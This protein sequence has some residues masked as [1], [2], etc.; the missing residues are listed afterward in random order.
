MKA[1]VAVVAAT[2]WFG[3]AC[4]DGQPNAESDPARSAPPPTTQAEP[5]QTPSVPVVDVQP[6]PG[7]PPEWVVV[8]VGRVE[9]PGMS[10]TGDY[11][12]GS[13]TETNYA[14]ACKGLAGLA[15]MLGLIGTAAGAV[16]SFGCDMVFSGD[17]Q[18]QSDPR[19]PDLVVRLQTSKVKYRSFVAFD[20]T[21]HSFDY[22]V[23]VPMKALDLSGV[24]L[25]VA[26]ADTDDDRDIA[27]V[28]FPPARLA[29]LAAEQ[30]MRNFA[31]DAGDGI[32]RFE[33]QATPWT[34]T[35]DVTKTVLDVAGGGQQLADFPIIAGQR[36]KLKATGRY[37]VGT[38]IMTEEIGPK[39]YSGA[40]SDNLRGDPVIEKAGHGATVAMV[41][42]KGSLHPVLVTPC[43]QFIAPFS[44]TIWIGVNDRDYRNNKGRV[45]ISVVRRQP[46]LSQWVA[47]SSKLD[48]K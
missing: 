41:G 32:A 35:T 7:P 38:V 29:E 1:L 24:E 21:N 23:L 46:A 45:E 36:V 48:C 8:R 27:S 47:K 11:W 19:A 17:E 9:V 12:D 31:H 4:G 33:V 20:R 5:P 30:S 43:A 14:E 34:A 18:Q 13:A 44:G 26:D 3:P 40:T 39:G 6:P 37:T 22:E 16:G 42:Q 28:R 10:P 25:V 15:S 2:T